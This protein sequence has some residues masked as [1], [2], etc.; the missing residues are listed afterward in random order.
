MPRGRELLG[1]SRSER[2]KMLAGDQY[3]CHDP[4]LSAMA[5]NVRRRVAE[6]CASDPG[7]EERRFELLG[8]IFAHVEAGVHIEPPFYV[9]YGVH[10]SIG[11]DTFINVNFVLI[12]DARVSIGQRCLFAPAV[13]LVTAMHPLDASKRRTS[14]DDVAAGSAVWRTM[15]APITIGDDVW[16]GSGVIVLPGVTIGDR[17]TVGAGSVVTDDVPPDCLAVGA[18]ARVIRRLDETT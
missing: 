4:E 17:C 8:A 9:D 7:D 3:N 13:Q 6:F 1:V 2:E 12:D 11:T 14:S 16:L 10:T 18:P 15:T 5:V